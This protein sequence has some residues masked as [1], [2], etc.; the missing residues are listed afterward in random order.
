[1]PAEETRSNAIS[2]NQPV[3]L[4]KHLTSNRSLQNPVGMKV[5]GLLVATVL[6]QLFAFGA[7]LDPTSASF[8]DQHSAYRHQQRFPGKLHNAKPKK[9]LFVF[10]IWGFWITVVFDIFC[11]GTSVFW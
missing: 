5:N 4:W 2:N 10:A 11:L 6:F 7:A 1:M 3:V 9:Y 8:E